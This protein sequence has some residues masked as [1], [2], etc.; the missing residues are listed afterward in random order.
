MEPFI[1]TFRA[2]DIRRRRSTEKSISRIPLRLIVDG[3]GEAKGELIRFLAPRTVDA[4]T[5][6]LPMEGRAALWKAEV[7][8]ETPLQM[9]EEKPKATVEKGTI[10]YWPMGKAFC[11]F[12]EDTRPYSPVNVIGKVAE[13]LSIFSQVKSGAK[14]RV[15]KT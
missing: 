1:K 11:I 15:E 8:F 5:R 4:L 7:Y 10:A 9:G 6:K 3:L 14:I 13:N 12:Y 2:N